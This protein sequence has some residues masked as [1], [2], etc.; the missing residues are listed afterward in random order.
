MMNALLGGIDVIVHL[1]G[2]IKR[3]LFLILLGT[4]SRV[5]TL[6][7]ARCDRT[8]DPGYDQTDYDTQ[9]DADTRSVT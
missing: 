9:S 8:C 5:H 6:H 1:V 7:A 3:A 4:G 2:Q